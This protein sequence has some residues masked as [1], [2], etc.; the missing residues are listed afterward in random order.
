MN[1]DVCVSRCLIVIGVRAGTTTGARAV[2]LLNTVIVLSAGRYLATGSSSLIRP[3]SCS[4]MTATLVMIL[5][6]E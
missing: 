4:A 5:D 2:P 6:I 3:S 1:P